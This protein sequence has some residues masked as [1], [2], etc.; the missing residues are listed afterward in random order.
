MKSPNI[1]HNLDEEF[2]ALS[3]VYMFFISS[4]PLVYVFLISG[5]V[6]EMI[7][8]ETLESEPLLFLHEKPRKSIFRFI[9]FKSS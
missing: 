1:P 6:V 8:H 4:N 3:R 5:N 2:R 7:H 9:F